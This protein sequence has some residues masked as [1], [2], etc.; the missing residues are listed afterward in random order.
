M[1][2]SKEA[3]HD[4]LE[5]SADVLRFAPIPG[6][7]EAA[8]VLLTIWDALQLVEVHTSYGTTFG[9]LIILTSSRQID[10]LV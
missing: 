5:V 3:A 8:R 2:Y 9:C 7:E 10:W 6:L 4:L 1:D